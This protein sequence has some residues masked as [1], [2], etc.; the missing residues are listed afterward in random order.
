[1]SE[2]PRKNPLGQSTYTLKNEGQEG[3]IGLF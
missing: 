3:K 2:M 1:M